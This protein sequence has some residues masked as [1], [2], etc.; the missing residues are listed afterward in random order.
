MPVS[1]E[2][3]QLKRQQAEERMIA[4]NKLT[5]QQKIDKAKSRRGE[6]KKELQRLME[7]LN[8]TRKNQSQQ[9]KDPG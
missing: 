8:G 5:T 9:N 3:K 4:H 7:E 1:K 6:S 2:V